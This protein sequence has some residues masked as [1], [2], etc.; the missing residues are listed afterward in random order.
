M[1]SPRIAA[2]LAA[3]L[4][5]PHL[6]S[7]AV[8]ATA[9]NPDACT[10]LSPAQVS[11]VLKVQVQPGQHL[12][13]DARSSCGW[14][15]PGDPSLGTKRL[16]F[17]IMSDRAFE[18]GKTPVK[19]ASKVPTQGVGD[20]AYYISMPPFGTALSVRRGERCFQVRI[21]GFPEVQAAHLEKT[22]AL[23]L[24]RAET[25]SAPLTSADTVGL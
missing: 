9:V 25:S 23:R 24:L 19:G 22:V 15:A 14:A 20:E 6:G 13:P 1:D 2:L 12:V 11:A 18:S 5:A 21:S 3:A 16:V 10:A 7:T 4:L 17:T 8:P